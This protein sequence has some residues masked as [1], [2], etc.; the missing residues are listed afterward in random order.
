MAICTWRRYDTCT[1]F[2][3]EHAD[4]PVERSLVRTRAYIR[5]L[6]EQEVAQLG[7]DHTK[8]CIGGNSQGC[9][10]ALNAALAFPEAVGGFVGTSGHLLEETCT[11]HVSGN[12]KQMH[13]W[14][15]V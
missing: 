11:D 2:E 3:G 6:I 12:H 7:G 10:A 5:S 13:I 9:I 15:Q 4:K 8:L 1:E 14:M